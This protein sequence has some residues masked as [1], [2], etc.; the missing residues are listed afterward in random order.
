MT[1]IKDTNNINY[2]MYRLITS[3]NGD[4]DHFELSGKNNDLFY[5]IELLSDSN[6]VSAKDSTGK[7]GILPKHLIQSITNN[8]NNNIYTAKT[9]FIGNPEC[10]EVTFS[11]G[12]SA[13]NI[14]ECSDTR[15]LFVKNTKTN[16]IG[17]VPKNIFF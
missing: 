5:N 12:D 11:P 17:V 15:W 16:D 3:Y 2:N 6:W 8:K 14:H 9:D 13:I 10:F 4:D 7:R 1:N